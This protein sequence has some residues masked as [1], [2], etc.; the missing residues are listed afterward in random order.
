MHDL[1][2]ILKGVENPDI[3]KGLNIENFQ[4][5]MYLNDFKQIDEYFRYNFYF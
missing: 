5:K 3:G 4:K 1:I 2:I